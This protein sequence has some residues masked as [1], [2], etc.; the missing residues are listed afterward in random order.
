M[1]GLEISSVERDSIKA[2]AKGKEVVKQTHCNTPWFDQ[3]FSE[4]AIKSKWVKLFWPQN[5]N[6]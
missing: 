1:E 3:E 2:S 6:D 5:P 4:L